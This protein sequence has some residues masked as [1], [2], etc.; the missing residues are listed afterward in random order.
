MFR[1]A[2][3][4]AHFWSK[5]SWRIE[6]SDN[7]EI[8]FDELISLFVYDLQLC[9]ARFERAFPDAVLLGHAA[10]SGRRI[11]F[12]KSGLSSFPAPRA[13]LKGLLWCLSL[14]ELD[15]F[16]RQMLLP[17]NS[18]RTR[19]SLRTSRGF[20]CLAEAYFPADADEID[21]PT[22]PLLQLLASAQEWRFDW[23]YLNELSALAH[24]CKATD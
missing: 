7:C 22:G 19:V 14:T 2:A 9:D 20:E 15:L 12:T 24:S 18:V 5:T 4:R 23:S 6:I 13:S 1:C 21:A 16:E 10:L 8:R 17:T 3:F 11:G